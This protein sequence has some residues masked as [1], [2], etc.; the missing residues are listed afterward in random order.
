MLTHTLALLPHSNFESS[1]VDVYNCWEVHVDNSTFE[2]NTAIVGTGQFRANS[3][4][5]AVAY[6]TS[7]PSNGS[8]PLVRV[9][10]SVFKSNRALLP[11]QNSS[12]QINLALNNHYYFGRGG[13]FGIFIDEVYAYVST[14]VS[15]CTFI[16]NYADSFGGGIYLYVDGNGTY[17]NFSV[18]GSTFVDNSAGEGSFGGGIEVALLIR[19]INS[20]PTSF[21]ISR[22][23][24]TN[25]TADFGGGLSFVQVYSQ[26]AGNSISLSDST[27]INNTANNV[28]SAVMFASL[29]YVQNRMES[30]HYKV[31]DW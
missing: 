23:E 3:G 29:L 22:C 14:E 7:E 25:N 2:N 13:G 28:G 10:G 26:G 6:H 30:L 5:L 31:R 20:P 1:A 17:H 4:G 11:T 12:Q 8:R 27:F 18:S 15:D 21:N 16:G 9:T 19:N 24:F